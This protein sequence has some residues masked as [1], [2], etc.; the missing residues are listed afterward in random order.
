MNFVVSANSGPQLIVASGLKSPAIDL[1]GAT[2]D[3]Y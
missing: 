2:M 3:K 1:I